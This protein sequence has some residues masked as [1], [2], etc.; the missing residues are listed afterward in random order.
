MNESNGSRSDETQEDDVGLLLGVAARTILAHEDPQ[1][2]LRWMEDSAPHLAP[3]L[4]ALA[5]DE[6]ARLGL[7]RVIGRAIWNA[8]PLPGNR[9]RPRPLPK[10]ERNDSCPCGSGQKY[11]R[12]CGTLPE[13]PLSP[14]AML[15]QV[16]EL[17][18]TTRFK[19]LPYEYLSP[20]ALAH[21]ASEWLTQGH[22][23]RAL[24]LIEP[25]FT[26]VGRLDARAESA[27]DVLADAYLELHRPKKK[28]DLIERV[29]RARDPVL[30]VAAL[31]RQCTV[32]SDQGR[33][34]EAWRLFQQA[35]R[36][37]PDHPAFSHLEVLLLIQEGRRDEAGE[38]AKFW[39]ARLKR[40]NA[41]EH[42]ELIAF[43]Q[44]FVADP[45]AAMTAITVARYPGLGELREIL[46]FPLARPATPACAIQH[47][48][49]GE[50]AFVPDARGR[51]IIKQ[52]RRVFPPL[53]VSLVDVHPAGAYA[54][55]PEIAPA[56]F[57]FLEQRPEAFDVIE[58]LDDL[59]LALHQVPDTGFVWIG[60]EVVA[61]LLER[62]RALV[63]AALKAHGAEHAEAPWVIWDNRPALRLIANF[64]YFRLDRKETAEAVRL[65][66]WMI[67]TLNPN[68]NHGLRDQLSKAYLELGSDENALALF[69][70]YPEDHMAAPAYNRVLALHRLGRLKEAA[71]ALNKVRAEWPNVYRYLTADNPKP[72]RLTPGRVQ[73]QGKDEAW[74]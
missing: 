55:D 62:A 59:V 2:F 64:I 58:I 70:R 22:A 9:F 45:D 17:W 25:L 50:V 6:D 21:T 27:F 48:P 1:Q 8:T 43:L 4:F 39:I 18:P 14:E 36:E 42:R 71:A 37:C 35:Q 28:S 34:E 26:D 68:D 52:W 49:R 16:L 23:E 10:P 63:E 19:E 29:S 33:R 51:K 61:P 66:E 74:Y 12:C 5:V 24:K 57:G 41:A 32:L 60:E 73:Y 30:R 69:E 72:P 46:K 54:W 40:D 3:R 56:W 13:F 15:C 44:G 67:Y 47:G 31:Q 7:A 11:K 20:E 38:R 53:E 65:M